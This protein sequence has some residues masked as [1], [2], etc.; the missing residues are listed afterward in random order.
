MVLIDIFVIRRR[1]NQRRQQTLKNMMLL[2]R[3]LESCLPLLNA[4]CIHIDDQDK[5]I[6]ATGKDIKN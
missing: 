2:C 5:T 4:Y 6:E 3:H 1:D